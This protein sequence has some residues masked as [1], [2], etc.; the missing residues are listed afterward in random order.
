MLEVPDVKGAAEYFRDVLGFTWDF[1]DAEY[2]VVWRDNSAVHFSRGTQPPAGVRL[3]HWLQDVDGYYAEIG[4]RGAE[5]TEGPVDRPYGLREFA[6]RG[7]EGLRI[8]FAQE[9]EE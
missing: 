9:I 3:F 6:V 1:G 8:V 7:P 2:S 4:A 5:V